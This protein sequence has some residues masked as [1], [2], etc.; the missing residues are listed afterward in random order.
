LIQNIKVW[1]SDE[2]PKR[3]RE[4]RREKTIVD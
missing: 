4:I 3:L 2:R 1:G